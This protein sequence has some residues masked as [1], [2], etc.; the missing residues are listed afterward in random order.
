[1]GGVAC[2][3]VGHEVAVRAPERFQ[4]DVTFVF[5]EPISGF[6]LTVTIFTLRHSEA[7]V[8]SLD[9]KGQ[10]SFSCITHRALMTLKAPPVRIMYVHVACK[11][12]LFAVG[13]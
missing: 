6:E 8:M 1:M 2:L 12:S 13:S 4:S 10:G 3:H 9:V 5:L 7:V 11:I